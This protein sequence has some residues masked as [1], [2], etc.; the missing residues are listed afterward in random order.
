[1]SELC[2]EI[3]EQLVGPHDRAL[4]QPKKTGK[5]K[6]GQGGWRCDLDVHLSSMY[7]ALIPAPKKGERD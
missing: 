5:E 7:E 1:M 3:A 2:E 6:K 4:S